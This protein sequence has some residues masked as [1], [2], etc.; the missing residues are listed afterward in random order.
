M[1]KPSK[2]ELLNLFEELC[3]TKKDLA[4]DIMHY[5][6]EKPHDWLLLNISSQRMFKCFDEIIVNNIDEE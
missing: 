4:L 6:N 3:K 2:T 1:W 5:A